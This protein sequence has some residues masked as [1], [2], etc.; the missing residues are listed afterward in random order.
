MPATHA[1]CPRLW[2]GDEVVL[3]APRRWMTHTPEAVDQLYLRE[4]FR[5]PARSRRGPPP[6]EPFTRAWF[7]QIERQRYIRHGA[8]IPRVL[9]FARHA[10]ET[11]LG[12][13]DGLG[14]D[15]LQYARHGAHVIA[16]AESHEQLGLIE[17]NF[18]LRDQEVRLAHA[19]PHAL[20]FD[21]ASIDVVCIQGLLHEVARP[22]LVIDE[23]YRILRPGGKVMAVAPAHF[24][25]AYWQTRLFPWRRWFRRGRRGDPPGATARSLK[26]DFARFAD[27][28]VKKRHLRRSHLPQLWR[29]LP[30]SLLERFLGQFLILKAFKPLS[31]ALAAQVAA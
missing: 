12:L 18:R 28:V 8:W 20:P 31:A 24:D 26:R 29:P 22:E 6:P 14:T 11:L 30:L 9:E 3:P 15:W 23:V 19:P 1:H 4:T 10:G 5:L 2:T 13:G 21:G 16:C 17:K 7:E 27:H 25:A